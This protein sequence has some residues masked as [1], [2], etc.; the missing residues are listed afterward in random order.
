MDK[1]WVEK[2]GQIVT[3]AIIIQWLV[4]NELFCSQKTKKSND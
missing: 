4:F 3:E 2:L 1:F